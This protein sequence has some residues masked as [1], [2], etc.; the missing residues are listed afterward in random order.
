MLR[1]KNDLRDNN[2]KYIKNLLLLGV[3]LALLGL[4]LIVGNQSSH[5]GIVEESGMVKIFDSNYMLQEKARQIQIIPPNGEMFFILKKEGAWFIENNHNAMVSSDVIDNFL[6]ELSNLYG[7]IRYNGDSEYEAFELTDDKSLSMQI[8][9]DDLQDLLHLMIG[10][11][12]GV[13]GRFI[14]YKGSKTV[15]E[16][17]NTFMDVIEGKEEGIPEKIDYHP[18]LENHPLKFYSGNLTSLE[19]ISG[20]KSKILKKDQPEFSETLKILNNIM[21]EDVIDPVNCLPAKEEQSITMMS[22]DGEKINLIFKPVEDKEKIM[23]KIV[24]RKRV[25]GYII[26]KGSKNNLFSL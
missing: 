1:I 6:Y 18:W 9:I 23:M 25:T 20:S 26:K 22:E 14:R 12:S 24:D 17:S 15:Y 19:I 10:K 5:K 11:K 4:F 7:E 3:F 8:K 2:M 16:V 13:T 21:I